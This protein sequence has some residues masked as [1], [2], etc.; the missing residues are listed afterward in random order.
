MSLHSAFHLLNPLQKG[1][2]SQ[3]PFCTLIWKKWEDGD[4]HFQIHF[5]ARLRGI[6]FLESIHALWGSDCCM[7]SL[8]VCTQH[9]GSPWGPHPFPPTAKREAPGLYSAMLVDLSL[10]AAAVF[11]IRASSHCLVLQGVI[12]LYPWRHYL[13]FYIGKDNSLHLLVR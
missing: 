2:P 8:A 3:H 12:F 6:L 7:K 5:W 9:A 4:W 13:L 1:P 10:P 11:K